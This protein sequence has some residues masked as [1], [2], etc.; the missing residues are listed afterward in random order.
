MGLRRF[1]AREEVE[2]A[3]HRTCGCC[4]GAFPSPL[5]ADER[6]DLPP[7]WPRP[8]LAPWPIRKCSASLSQMANMNAILTDR[9]SRHG[10]ILGLRAIRL[11]LPSRTRQVSV[12]LLRAS[13]TKRDCP[14]R[15]S[16]HG[17]CGCFILMART[18]SSYESCHA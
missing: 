12:A 7:A 16:E 8:A 15:R 13:S 5:V 18:E 11:R 14:P 9:Q 6:D 2:P 17:F 4:G 3:N 10:P 1:V